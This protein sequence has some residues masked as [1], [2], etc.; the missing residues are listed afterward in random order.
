[1]AG[2]KVTPDELHTGAGNLRDT[3]GRIGDELT[4]AKG[5]VN[6]LIGPWEGAAMQE[7]DTLM[8]K[9]DELARAQAENLEEI[10]RSLDAAATAY[11]DTEDSVRQAFNG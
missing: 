1:M 6:R 3:A 5:E 2:F 9:W 7:F 8:K 10:S 4:R 11:A